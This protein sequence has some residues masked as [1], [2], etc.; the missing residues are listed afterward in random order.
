MGYKY[1]Y[2]VVKN[3]PGTP[4]RALLKLG[5]ALPVPLNCPTSG[6]RHASSIRLLA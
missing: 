6:N 1:T 2:G 5:E 3:Y 4:S